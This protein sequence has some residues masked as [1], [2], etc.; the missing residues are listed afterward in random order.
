M[1]DSSGSHNSLDEEAF[2]TL[3]EHELLSSKS[4]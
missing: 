1:T 4:L 2:V 3:D